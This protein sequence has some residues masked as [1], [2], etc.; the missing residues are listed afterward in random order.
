[1]FDTIGKTKCL[2]CSELA[3][4]LPNQSQSVVTHLY[5]K[6]CG[7]YNIT[8][9]AELDLESC[10]NDIKYILSSQIFEKYY[11]EQEPL[12][13]LTEH[14]KNAKDIPLLEKLFKLSKYLY[15][16]TKKKSL[17]SKIDDISC[18]QFYCRTDDEFIQLLETLKSI[19]IINIVKKRGTIADIRPY[20]YSP[21]MTVNAMLAFDE[22]IANV[23]DF[24]KVFMNTK[25]DGN[26]IYLNIPEGKNQ[27]N[28]ATNGA[29]INAIQ[30]NSLDITELNTLI[31]NAVKS[32]PQN[33]SDEKREEATENLEF[34]KTEIQNSNPRKAII[35]NTLLALKAT[36]TTAGFFA[37]LAKIFEFFGF[38]F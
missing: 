3:N 21:I 1:M 12:T 31:E 7:E 15:H 29:T 9:Q 16:E 27:F 11:Y 24:K 34:I 26:Q 17:G 25:T 32:L 10:K 18:S 30:N 23:E 33:I 8:M 5:C 13:I 22:G 20:I 14:I 4:V 36:V 2:L 19:N 28:I 6:N 38:K 37:S 35:K